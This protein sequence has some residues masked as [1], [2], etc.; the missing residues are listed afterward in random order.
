MNNLN[1]KKQKIIG[2][3][4]GIATGK[5]TVSQY[6]FDR[7]Y[8]PIFD[9]DII[10]RQAVEPNSPILAKIFDRYGNQITNQYGSLNRSELGNIIFKNK[11]EKQWLEKQIHPFV[12]NYFTDVT[13]ELNEPLIVFVIPLLFEAKMT[14][15][16]SEIW[17]VS[18]TL[19]QE[20]DRLIQRNNLTLTE[21]KAR[22]QSQIPVTEKI[23]QADVVIN[24]QGN[25][26]QLYDQIDRIMSSYFHKS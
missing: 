16:V 14:D 18:C 20:I 17:V 9:A 3:T 5:S 1:V 21:A 7:Y 23:Q 12:Y 6:L 11:E 26:S 24:N 2:L 25:L 15:L 8:L 10:A 4:G 19:E 13:K 22:I